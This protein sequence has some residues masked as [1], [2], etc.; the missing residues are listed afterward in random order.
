L[1]EEQNDLFNETPKPTE[2]SGF[3]PLAARMRPR[4]FDE[5]VGQEHLTGPGAAFR[6]AAEA[7]KL[8]SVVLWGPPGVGKTTLAELVAKASN[9]VFERVSATSA[10]V[11]DLRKVIE[12]ARKS[13][14]KGHRTLLFI[15]EIHRFNKSQQDAI[16]PVVENGVITLV[17]ATT[18]NPSFEVN[19]ALLS[20]SR[21]FVLNALTDAEIHK[22]IR[23]AL[24]DKERGVAA[25]LTIASNT[26]TPQHRNTDEDPQVSALSSQPLILL[27]SDA[28]DALVNLSNGDARS[29]L[30]MLELSVAVV[31]AEGASSGRNAQHPTPNASSVPP[32]S[33]R[34]HEKSGASGPEP[35]APSPEP[36]PLRITK[37][38]VES[39]VQR[40]TA[41]YDKGGEMHFDLI[42]A[43]HK[44]VRGSDP[45]ATLYWLA[46]ML[47]GGED[48]LYLARRIIRMAVEDVGMADPNALP[49]AIAA[50]QAVH[51]IG[52]PEG[53]LALAQAAVYMATAPK[54]NSLYTAYGA[55]KSDVAGTRNDPVPIHLRNAPTK[56]MKD[57]G[58]G[59]DYKYAHD[60][61]EGVVEQ[62]NLPDAISGR[63]YYKPTRRGY[64]KTVSE[65][66]EKWRQIMSERKE[67]L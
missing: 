28:E 16:L 26:V 50:Q 30:N 27:D 51:F 53:E 20:R 17:G 54:S 21:V 55:V 29:A 6:R 59:K 7:G 1:L 65:R 61:E 46:R 12:A 36:V 24:D 62:Q 44:S 64:E 18:E 15:D 39:A 45:D 11:A 60:F 47:D 42:S 22:V 40:R 48:P 49:V 67:Q 19:S 10:G 13:Q 38:I 32:R 25:D 52:L 41:L 58:Y 14:Q 8:G 4:T 9:S 34:L 56:L 37:A 5:F 23:S 33:P 35:R 57:I 31:Q 2:S 63:T 3:E 66:L 43:L